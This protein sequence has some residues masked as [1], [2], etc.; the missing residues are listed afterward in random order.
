MYPFRKNRILLWFCGYKVYA[1][2]VVA[3]LS[4]VR[5]SFSVVLQDCEQFFRPSSP[6]TACQ[7]EE[8]LAQGLMAGC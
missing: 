6:S 8:T 2:L 1:M 4:L 5:Q 7:Y 3:C